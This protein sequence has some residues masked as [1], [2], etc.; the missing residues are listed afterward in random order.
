[1][2]GG[3]R[4]TDKKGRVE[5]IADL[6]ISYVGNVALF[7]AKTPVPAANSGAK[8]KTRDESCAESASGEPPITELMASR[9]CTGSCFFVEYTNAKSQSSSPPSEMLPGRPRHRPGQ[10]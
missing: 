4:Q 3:H 8:Q 10:S 2:P 5:R 9:N 7:T 6:S 1:M